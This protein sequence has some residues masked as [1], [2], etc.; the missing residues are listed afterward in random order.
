MA[1][2]SASLSE[3]RM[4]FLKVQSRRQRQWN[5]SGVADMIQANQSG[6]ETS[7]AR[8]THRFGRL[9]LDEFCEKRVQ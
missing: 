9:K 4:K 7:F 1:A 2:K 6:F 5:S 8:R 3:F